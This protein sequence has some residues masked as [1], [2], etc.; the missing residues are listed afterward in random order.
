VRPLIRSL[1]LLG[2]LL[3]GTAMAP[4][5]VADDAA[6]VPTVRITGTP[7]NPSTSGRATFSWRADVP[8]GSGVQFRCR[9]T[10]PGHSSTAF[11][12]C[13]AASGQTSTTETAGSRTF[14]GLGASRSAYRFTVQAFIPAAGADP[15]RAG[16]SDSYSWRVFSV[17]A[18]HAY[19]L[20]NGPSFNRPLTRSAQRANLNRVIRTINAMP[21]YRQA[22]PGLCPNDPALVPGIIHVSLYSM[23]DRRFAAAMI[24]ARKRCLSVQI[25]MNNHLNRDNDPAWR[26]LEDSLGT[27]VFDADGTARRTFAH[28]C[29]F[30]CR[31]HGVLHTK[32]YLFNSTFRDARFN[33]IRNTVLVGSSNMTSNASKVQWND[34]F[35]QRGNADLFA[36]FSGMF[37]RLKLDNG[38][39]PEARTVTNGPFQT[40]FMPQQS[41]GDPYAKALGA[42][43]CTGATGGAGVHGRTLLTMNMHAWFGTRGM[44]LAKKVRSLY[45]HG[46]YVRV[47]YSFM[48]F[49]VFKQLERGTNSRMSVRRTIFSHNGKTAYVYSHF[50]N[51]DISGHVGSQTNARI[52]YT[53][54]NNFT[55]DGLRRF[56][57]VI[58]RIAS[59]SAYRAYAHQ[60]GYIRARL[61]SAK[62]AN[63]AEPSGGGRVPDDPATHPKAAA[64]APAGTPTIQSPDVTVDKNGQPHALD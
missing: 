39:H 22:Y 15:E 38:F 30:A 42:I 45:A 27:K 53:G 11:E 34:L 48:S 1:L 49:K 44:A 50:K 6:A 51:I 47:L 14:T 31:G 41:T 10:G 35:A 29:N 20:A 25:L 40:T 28:R 58:I 52:V 7:D 32:M 43:R 63:F 19:N 17:F 54:S 60:Y 57:E 3:G 62:Y 64:G 2:L 55:N 36:T 12:S 18:P 46:C 9:L 59:T 8:S 56:D 23:T 16:N 37:N 61:S 33:K 24:A 13:P 4:L 5:A 26:I 21:G